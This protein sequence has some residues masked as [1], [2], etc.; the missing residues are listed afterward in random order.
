MAKQAREK[1]AFM[2]FPDRLKAT[3]WLVMAVILLLTGAVTWQA[4]QPA[5][6]NDFTNWDDPRYVVENENLDLSKP[7]HWDS[8]K[9]GVFLANYHPLTMFSL[10]L[11]NKEKFP[12][13]DPY[14]F[15]LTNVRLHLLNMVLIFFLT[16]H[17]SGRRIFVASLTALWFGIHPMHVESVAWI[18]ERKDVLYTCFFLLAMLAYWQYN[19]SGLKWYWLGLAA[20]LFVLSVLSKAMAIVLPAVF[21]LMDYFQGRSWKNWRVWLEKLPLMAFTLLMGLKAWDAQASDAINDF[22]TFTL[23]QRTM[24]AS[25]GF[26][27]YIKNFFYPEGFSTFY[28][29][30]KLVQGGELEFYWNLFPFGVLIIAALV[31][32]SMRKTKWLAFCF[33]FYGVTLIMVIQ[34]VSVGAAIMA[35]RYTYIP[36]T[37]LS[38]L[39]GMGIC[40]LV[41]EKHQWI[42]GIGGA[43][44]LAGFLYGISLFEKTQAQCK[45]W[46][47]PETLWT[48]V[49]DQYPMRVAVAYKNRG[50]FRAKN[51]QRYDDALKDYSALVSMK[52]DDAKVYSNLGNLYGL[53]GEFDKALASYD[54]AMKMSKEPQ[55]DVMMNRGVTLTKMNR[56]SEAVMQFE[57]ALKLK[58]GDPLVIQNL[59]FAYMQTKRYDEAI[60]NYEVLIKAQPNVET[61]YYYAGYC[62]LQVQAYDA[63]LKHLEQ[64]IKMMPTRSQSWYFAAITSEKLG[65]IQKCIQYA[66]K[67]EELGYSIPAQQRQRWF[68]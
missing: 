68:K 33:G 10:A 17:L 39:L 47:N 1:L 15:H 26:L 38:L 2:I 27:M 46:K 14:P 41:E 66:K 59:A 20:L 29:Y 62:Y 23:W 40:W 21:L 53:R 64:S 24:F 57:N 16:F 7:A 52:T 43:L 65:Q 30:P 61:N 54:K 67:S 28:P 6:E 9:T 12:K 35:D 44:L 58:P 11:D 51:L 50:N 36:Y 22:E 63:A 25:F 13:R 56:F 55:Y 60:A 31:I 49:I 19:K 18:A 5:L 45:I 3:H 4:Y 48:Q 37:A 32:W 34:F 42:N 8:L